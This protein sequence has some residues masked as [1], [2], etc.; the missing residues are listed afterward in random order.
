MDVNTA[1]ADPF[2]G[3]NTSGTRVIGLDTNSSGD[4][5]FYLYSSG[6]TNT[7]KIHSNSSTYFNGGNVGIGIAPGGSVT[8]TLQ[9]DGDIFILTLVMLLVE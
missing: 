6:G 9:V 3:Y 7:I 4:G 8:N 1:G 2:G 5:L